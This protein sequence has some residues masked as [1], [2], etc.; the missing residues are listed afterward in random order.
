MAAYVGRF[1]PSPTG[2]LHFGSLI[3]ALASFLDARANGGAWLIR[4]EDIDPPREMAG[5]AATILDCLE[6]HG[7]QPDAP[8]IYQSCHLQRYYA[9]VQR[10]IDG[11]HAFYC[12]CSRASLAG[13]SVYPGHCRERREQPAEPHAIRLRVWPGQ[14]AFDDLVQ[15]R[16]VQDVGREVGDFVIW[17]KEDLPAYQLAVVLDDALQGVTRVIRG[18]DLLDNTPRQI[19]LRERLALPP[20]E[21]AHV[22]VIANPAGQKL[23]KQTFAPALNKSQAPLNLRAALAFLAQPAPPPLAIGELLGWATE[24]WQPRRIPARRLL[25]GTDLPAACRAFA[26]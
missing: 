3:G 5:A 13:H 10:L 2:P 17:R 6:N 11:G 16:I 4:I 21:Y 24:H 22:P 12:T 7:L 20:L 26:S 15:G 8:V 23:S 9:A 14:V 25:S 18:S 19:L 1:A